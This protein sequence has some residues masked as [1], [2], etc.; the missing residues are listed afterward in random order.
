MLDARPD[1][2]LGSEHR[3]VDFHSIF[4]VP[5]LFLDELIER[6]G[7]RRLRLLPPYREHLSQSFA[8]FFMRVR[9]PQNITPAW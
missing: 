3:I 6:R 8:R 4:T 5:R 7:A 1:G 9:L 2:E